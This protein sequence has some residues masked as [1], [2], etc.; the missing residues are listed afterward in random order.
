M[1]VRMHVHVRV[2]VRTG[3]VHACML[4]GMHALARSAHV[5]PWMHAALSCFVLADPPCPVC[6]GTLVSVLLPLQQMSYTVRRA[7]CRVSLCIC[8]CVLC[9]WSLC[10]CEG[11]RV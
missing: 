4:S 10:V 9:L 2:C 3:Q 5:Q 11:V 1:R 7:L 6:V 8:V